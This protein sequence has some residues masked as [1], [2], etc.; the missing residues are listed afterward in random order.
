MDRPL[1]KGFSVANTH[2]VPGVSGG[3]G[4]SRMVTMVTKVDLA[5]T[6]VEKELAQVF[7][8]IMQGLV[9]K[10]RGLH[11]CLLTNV[12]FHL[13]LPE[14]DELQ[15]AVT[16]MATHQCPSPQAQHLK[17]SQ[18][19]EMIFAM[20]DPAGDGGA[21]NKRAT[22][23]DLEEH[24]GAQAVHITPMPFLPGYHVDRYLGIINLFLIRESTS[25]KEH[26]GVSS[27]MHLFI[28]EAQ[29]IARA[30]VA[31][32]GGNALQSYRLSECELIEHPHKN[33]AQC[34]LNLSGDAVEL[35]PNL[36][37][38]SQKSCTNSPRHKASEATE[39][40]EIESSPKLSHRRPFTSAAEEESS[41]AEGRVALNSRAE[42]T[43]GGGTSAIRRVLKYHVTKL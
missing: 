14:N 15:V 41:K 28:L 12:K 16:A 5:G 29:A 25:I 9:F 37:T 32:L 36:E 10:V 23:P 2:S 13:D 11:P 27:F 43:G 19:D 6:K 18:S 38:V 26:G 35:K 30:H 7:H 31:G 33:Q 40:L 8:S 17:G 21:V 22:T 3:C 42:N 34:L 4:E 20:E 1:P 24:R 39:V